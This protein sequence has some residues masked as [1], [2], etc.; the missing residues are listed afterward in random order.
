MEIGVEV[1]ICKPL[2]FAQIILKHIKMQ[3]EIITKKDLENLKTDLLTELKQIISVSKPNTLQ[4]KEWLK[5]HEVRKLLGISPGTLQ[6]MRVN[7]TIKFSK[8]GGIF[9]YSY[10]DIQKLLSAGSNQTKAF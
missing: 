8:V 10:S 7:G 6:T 2:I 1:F 9:Y 4:N 3:F 5:S